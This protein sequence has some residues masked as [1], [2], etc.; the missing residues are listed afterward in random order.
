MNYEVIFYEDDRGRS[1]VK[2]FLDQ[3]DA[4]AGNSKQASKTVIKQDC[5]VH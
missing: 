1:P 4:K 2:D 3:L 5:F